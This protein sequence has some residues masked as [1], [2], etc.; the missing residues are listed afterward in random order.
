MGVLPFDVL[1]ITDAIACHRAG[2][3]VLETIQYM[4]ADGDWP[5]VAVLLRDK[6]SPLA[7]VENLLQ[8]LIPIV[9][10]ANAHLL[11]HSYPQLALDY[12][13]L[14]VHCAAAVS[15]AS[16]RATL[17]AQFLL[18]VSRH[19]DDPLDEQDIG[20]SHYATISP[21]F[22]PTSKP[23]DARATLGLAGL[24]T[25]LQRSVRPLVALGGIQ[26]H[27]GAS[28]ISQGAAAIAISGAILQAESPHRILKAFWE[29]LPKSSQR[30]A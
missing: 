13:L 24:K 27:H 25:C 19:G 1:V 22:L 30:T 21:I 17:G 18:G 28:L 4:F 8:K 5:R 29:A 15:L 23:L 12:G 11:I 2:R 14:G 16:M 26:P 9:S 10:Q 7:E 3:T 20:L 6:Q